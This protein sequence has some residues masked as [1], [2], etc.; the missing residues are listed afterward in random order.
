MAIQPQIHLCT[1]HVNHPRP[2]KHIPLHFLT[3]WDGNEDAPNSMY[4]QT[5]PIASTGFLLGMARYDK[6]KNERRR[7][8]KQR[9]DQRGMLCF[10][11]VSFLLLVRPHDKKDRT[12]PSSPPLLSALHNKFVSF[13]PNF[14]FP[15]NQPTLFPTKSLIPPHRRL[16]K[17]P[18]RTRRRPSRTPPSCCLL[19]RRRRRHRS[20]GRGRPPPPRR[21]LPAR[22]QAR[23]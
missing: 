11:F 20:C 19:R 17:R 5:V 14:P 7:K 1:L 15:P 3:K 10:R 18:H 6:R 23:L 12:R 13:W 22:S 21:A 8:E 2:K 9:D 4:W 16:E